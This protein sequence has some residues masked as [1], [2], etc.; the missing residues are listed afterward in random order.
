MEYLT[1]L[2]H[3]ND[4]YRPSLFELA[5]QGQ[6]LLSRHFKRYKADL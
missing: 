5:A 6:S 2:S 1:D 4:P 3:Q